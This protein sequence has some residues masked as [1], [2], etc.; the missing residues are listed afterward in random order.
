V[1]GPT[2]TCALVTPWAGATPAG[3]ADPAPP[4]RQRRP[5]GGERL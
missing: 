1:S 4:V 5:P 3:A 2:R